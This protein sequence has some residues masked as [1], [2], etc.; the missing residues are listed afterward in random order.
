MP[1]LNLNNPVISIVDRNRGT[2]TAI[3]SEV[4]QQD[5]TTVTRTNVSET[6]LVDTE[7]SQLPA[8]PVA[9]IG[10][11]GSTQ[12]D[13]YQ[14]DPP[15]YSNIEEEDERPSVLGT[16]RRP[17]ALRSRAPNNSTRKRL[18]E[19]ELFRDMLFKGGPAFRLLSE[20]WATANP[21]VRVSHIS[22]KQR[23][24]A[25]M[26]ARLSSQENSSSSQQS[27]SLNR[28]GAVFWQ[29][30]TSPPKG[31][32]ITLFYK[33]LPH[34]HGGDPLLHACC[35]CNPTHEVTAVD[36]F[37]CAH[38]SEF[39]K[40][41]TVSD[42]FRAALH[43]STN[44]QATLSKFGDTISVLD[45]YPSVHLL[46]S[47]NSINHNPEGSKKTH[48]FYIQF[49]NDRNL[50]CPLV[51]DKKKRIQ[52]LLC[53][54]HC[55]RRGRCPHEV[56]LEATLDDNG[57]HSDF[58]SDDIDF[59]EEQS[60]G[61]LAEE[62][63][64]RRTPTQ[65]GQSRIVKNPEIAN[66]CRTDIKLPLL[67][68][69]EIRRDSF[70]VGTLI[71][72]CKGT[73]SEK[74]YDYYGTCK[75]C[76]YERGL[77]FL[78][79]SLTNWR[80][81][82]LFTLSHQIQVVE[83]EDWKCPSCTKLVRFCGF[84]RAI[85]PVRKT[86]AF[87]YELMY[88]FVN[89]V[90][91]LGISFRA[92][93]DSFHMAQVSQSALARMEQ[94]ST[95]FYGE[96]EECS[97]GR[98]RC[99]EAF[100]LFL[101]CI[102]TN[103]PKICNELFTCKDC[104]RVISEEE[105][106][107]LGFPPSH[108]E[109][110]KRFK[111]LAIDGTTAGILHKLPKYERNSRTLSVTS[112][113]QKNQRAFTSKLYKN[114]LKSFTSLICSRLR[115][116]VN[117]QRHY[118]TR[119]E[120]FRF[121]I[122]TL[123]SKKLQ[124]GKK[125]FLDDDQLLCIRRLLTE[126]RCFCSLGPTATNRRRKHSE[127]CRRVDRACKANIEV[128]K[129]EQFIRQVVSLDVQTEHEQQGDDDYVEPDADLSEGSAT[130]EEPISKRT[131]SQRMQQVLLP[132]DQED[133]SSSDDS[134]GNGTDLENMAEEN[135]QNQE[136][137]TQINRQSQLTSGATGRSLKKWYILIHIP[138]PRRCGQLI[139]SFLEVLQFFLLHNVSIPYIRPSG[140]VI[141]RTVDRDQWVSEMVRRGNHMFT[142]SS[143]LKLDTDA[144]SRDSFLLHSRLRV[145]LEEF[146]SCTCNGNSTAHAPCSNC[147]RI[148]A[149]NSSLLDDVN[150]VCASFVAQLVL[151]TE[152]LQGKSRELASLFSGAVEEHCAAAKNYFNNLVHN[153]S[154]DCQD[155]WRQFASCVLDALPLETEQ[156]REE[157]IQGATHGASPTTTPQLT[158]QSQEGQRPDLG[159]TGQ[160]EQ[161]QNSNGQIRSEPSRSSEDVGTEHHQA[162]SPD[163]TMED[164]EEQTN[165]QQAAPR[166]P[167]RSSITGMSFPG[168]AQ[169][170][171]LII[172]DQLEGKQCGKRYAQ[173][174]NHSPGLLT[175]QCACSNSKFIGFI[176]MER[177][178]ST[179]L[180]LAIILMFFAIPPEII[181]YDNACNCLS[182]ALLRIPWLLVFSL[183]IVDRFHYKGHTCNAFFDADRYKTLDPVK[184]SAA[185]INNSRLK[186]SLYNMR[187]LSGETLVHYLNVR[188]ALL[189]LNSKYYEL[190]Q[191]SDM[192]DAN[193]EEFYASLFQCSCK[194]SLFL[195][196]SNQ[197]LQGNQEDLQHERQDGDED[198]VNTHL[199]V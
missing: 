176:V 55:V 75:F 183:I 142:D 63:N 47:V 161:P 21:K 18:T 112:E 74:Y 164:G 73:Y 92:Q 89:N 43:P 193:L 136:Q 33:I 171:P 185:E 148:L 29:T 114:S 10:T 124:K 11:G 9:P 139:E 199:V 91:R 132:D 57:E 14:N 128:T 70:E 90:C 184:T 45:S 62:N 39:L 155:Y 93:Y 151:N 152:I 15:Q 27:S 100:S 194:T 186:R 119:C 96:M 46:N 102:D 40:S 25:I 160:E 23:L 189:N 177:A 134:R 64:E 111:C 170:R 6:Q 49:D 99:A 66:Y 197:L 50:F 174:T 108:T 8:E 31:V 97:S 54:T 115:V 41:T 198:L 123:K 5:G 175:V 87:T 118:P 7:H 165:T 76:S 113:L 149:R 137:Q 84:A 52:C 130:D 127:Q 22:F 61:L 162:S 48:S 109:P 67:P 182:S 144:I 190:H 20:T 30:S 166:I 101:A 95:Q 88:Y 28:F 78:P 80:Q 77:E 24:F 71:E 167:D 16:S 131:R 86:Y 32:A 196:D 146:A 168:R 98:R 138:N 150:P 154:N 60:N 110:V 85:F 195:R 147:K 135:V 126:D 72:Q 191:K 42:H 37:T 173:N 188:L 51:K 122:P 163:T 68:C 44:D 192:E 34:D 36:K 107:L 81:T 82:K 103:D 26:T 4:V 3:Q 157:N 169:C 69:T 59:F 129:I 104:E 79:P 181:L 105:K 13:Q 187:F 83:V 179:A 38:I 120:Y 159:V 140:D 12:E 156:N 65:Q 116:I 2:V 94:F 125:Y 53:R 17:T 35:S 117:C 121:I 180:A 1:R 106:R 19:S 172:F 153:L 56:Q 145:S 158:F 133:S 58:D 143:V 141:E 178:E